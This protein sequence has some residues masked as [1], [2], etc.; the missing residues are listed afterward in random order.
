[1]DRR[2]ENLLGVVAL[3][4]ED[5]VR[6]ALEVR[7]ALRGSGSAAL[8]HLAGHPGDSTESLARVLAISQPGTVATVERLVGAGLVERRPGPDRRTG[9]LH[10]T[11]AGLAV[12]A[13]LLDARAAALAEVLAPL[14]DEA[15]GRLTGL[16]EGVVAGLADDRSGALT[17]CRRCDRARCTAGGCPL[18]HTVTTPS[19]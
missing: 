8:V 2:L 3:A 13:E 17:A 5:R 15:R 14:D 18:D 4:V 6:P 10:P 12:L 16:L 7:P 19:P 9:S 11:A 1:M